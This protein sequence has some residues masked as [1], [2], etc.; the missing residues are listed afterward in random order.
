MTSCFYLNEV[1]STCVGEQDARTT[2]AEDN[3]GHDSPALVDVAR[4]LL[5][6]LIIGVLHNICSNIN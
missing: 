2:C 1:V 6:L 4:L 3:L 5:I